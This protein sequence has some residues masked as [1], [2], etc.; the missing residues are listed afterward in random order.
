VGQV[1]AHSFYSSHAP[2]QVRSNEL[3]TRA[4][5]AHRCL[6]NCSVQMSA[7]EVITAV[8]NGDEALYVCCRDGYRGTHS[9]SG[10]DNHRFVLLCPADTFGCHGISSRV[11]PV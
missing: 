8:A 3:A 6:D 5:G 7:E 10:F 4:T 2:I 1:S 9:V 11:N